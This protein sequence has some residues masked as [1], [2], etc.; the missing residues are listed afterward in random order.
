VKKET[1][2]TSAAKRQ[3]YLNSFFVCIFIYLHLN[4]YYGFETILQ[5][6]YI[7]LLGYSNKQ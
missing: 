5:K 4:I 6:N 7:T 2:A 1:G 3:V